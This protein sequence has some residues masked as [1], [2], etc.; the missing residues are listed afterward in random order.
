[1]RMGKAAH[2]SRKATK[3]IARCSGPILI[4]ALISWARLPLFSLACWGCKSFPMDPPSAQHRACEPGE[5][6][7]TWLHWEAQINTCRTENRIDFH[8]KSDY[9]IFPFFF[10]PTKTLL[11]IYNWL[12]QDLQAHRSLWVNRGAH[13]GASLMQPGKRRANT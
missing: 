6:T 10:S 4:L 12:N 1:M 9:F 3:L 7:S 13:A 2:F 11:L 5:E 8:L